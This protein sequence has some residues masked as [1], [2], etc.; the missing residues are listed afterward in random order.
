MMTDTYSPEIL[1]LRWSLFMQKYVETN[2][3]IKATGLLIRQENMPE[4]ITENM[5]KFIIRR[6]DPTVVWSK[7]VGKNGD[8]CSDTMK[9]IEVK[10]FTSNGPCTFGPNKKFDVI[11]FLDLRNML[12]NRIILFKMN[13]TNNSPEWKNLKMNK[14]QTSATK[15][16]DLIYAGTKYILN[17]IL[18]VRLYLTIHLKTFLHFK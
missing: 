12:H 16:E 13:L 4:D 15:K 6:E 7:C 5:V 3:I 1:Q 8:L 10:S 2:K 9:S 17:L 11:Y 14:P 18:I